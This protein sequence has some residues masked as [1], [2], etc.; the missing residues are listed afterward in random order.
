MSRVE[1]SERIKWKD[2]RA[3][4]Q[5]EALQADGKIENLV[6]V[7]DIVNN[8]RG[9]VDIAVGVRGILLDKGPRI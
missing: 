2:G 8:G 7:G 5:V 6:V 3:E 9:V 4:M 1:T